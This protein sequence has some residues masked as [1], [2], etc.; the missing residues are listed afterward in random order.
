MLIINEQTEHLIL[1]T[2]R[3]YLPDGTTVGVIVVGGHKR[4]CSRIPEPPGHNKLAYAKPFSALAPVIPRS[5]WPRLIKEQKAAKRRVSDFQSFPPHD[6][7]GLPSCWRNGTAHA[8][9]T[10]RVIAG[11]PYVEL[12]ANSLCPNVSYHSGGYE[13][14]SAEWMHKYGA[15]STATMPNN[16]TNCPQGQQ[17]DEE[18]KHHIAIEM[19]YLE[20]DATQRFA[21]YATAALLGYCM[22]LAFDR[23]SHVI[24]GG[25]L[26]QLGD[27]LFGGLNRNNWGNWGE[28]NDLGQPGYIIQQEGGW[29]PS[30]GVVLRAMTASRT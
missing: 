26:V 13:G 25:D 14:D 11:H 7:D 6:Q 18:R 1:P 28:K 15:L 27:D 20:G 16:S 23:W 22:T 8:G 12:S 24:S 30:S 19:Y 17:Y 9:T 2:H 3:E 29:T 21:Q 10:S 5:E 4:Y